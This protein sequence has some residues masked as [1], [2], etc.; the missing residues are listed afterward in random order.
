MKKPK[1]LPLTKRQ[2]QVLRWIE[3]YIAKHR[4]APSMREIGVGMRIGSPNGVM[5]HLKALE[6]KGWI[7]R[8]ANG[9]SRAM[10][11]VEA[12]NAR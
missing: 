2:A 12:D 8:S 1:Q 10:Y 6:R 9:E 3:R 7:V 4:W 5:G 11:V